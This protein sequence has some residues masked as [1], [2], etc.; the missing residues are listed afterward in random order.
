LTYANV[1]ATLAMFAV[2]GG[3]AYA[4]KKIGSSDIKKNA[5]RSKHIKKN[6]VKSSDIK[7][8]QVKASDIKDGQVKAAEIATGAVEGTEIGDGTIGGIDIAGDALGGAQ[9]NEGSLGKVPSAV[10]ADTITGTKL[11]AFDYE[12]QGGGGGGANVTTLVDRD[13][14][15][16]KAQCPA[17]GGGISMS[18]FAETKLNNAEIRFHSSEADVSEEGTDTDFDVGE[19][20][21]LFNGGGDDVIGTAEY[22]NGG[23][24]VVSV[25]FHGSRSFSDFKCRASGHV[26]L[27]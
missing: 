16:L 11:V 3:G 21:K 8:G 18:I 25:Q 13:N 27:S 26:L 9:I 15:V 1:M 24:N 19:D 17:G 22:R 6:Q 4:A 20:F 23:Q 14:F 5:G 12:V 2:L 7:N 10:T